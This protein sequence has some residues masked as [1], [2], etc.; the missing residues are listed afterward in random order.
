MYSFVDR[1]CFFVYII[2]CSDGTFYT[3]FTTDIERRILV[4]NDGKG[5]KYTKGRRPVEL[6]HYESYPS[7]SLALAREYAIKHLT[8]KQKEQLISSHASKLNKQFT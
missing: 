8:R 2:R 5:A 1:Q 3:G 4:H 7:K 6:L